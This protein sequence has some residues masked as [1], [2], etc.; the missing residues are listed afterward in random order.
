MT[1]ARQ[2]F[3]S[4]CDEAVAMQVYAQQAKGRTLI[5]DATNIRMRSERRAE[6][7]HLYLWVPNNAARL[8]ADGGLGLRAQVDHHVAQAALGTGD[9][10][11]NQ[12]EHALF[13]VR[14][15]LR[16]RVDDISTIF[17]PI[18]GHSE[19]PNRHGFVNLYEP[20]HAQE[21]RVSDTSAQ[22]DD[23]DIPACLR[24]AP[25]KGGVS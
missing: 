5:E 20:R 15:E 21:P 3:K 16:T 18:G 12:T 22:D 7:C 13:G 9:Y 8:R 19:K 11:R 2:L 4:A 24:R 1:T 10:F 17:A 14:G 23:L 6:N 25:T